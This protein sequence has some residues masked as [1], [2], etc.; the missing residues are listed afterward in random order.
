ML[1]PLPAIVPGLMIQ[2]PAGK[3]FIITLPVA[4]EQVGCAIVPIIGTAG[5]MGC[6][7]ITIFADTKEVHPS[8]LVTA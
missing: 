4:N 7:L 6:V 2:S 3:P 8:A 5:V 1:A